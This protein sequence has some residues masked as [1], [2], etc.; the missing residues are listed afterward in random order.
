MSYKI[1]ITGGLIGLAMSALASVNVAIADENPFAMSE[2][3]AQG[4]SS[5]L[6]FVS[7]NLPQNDGKCGGGKC[8]DSDPKPK[9]GS[10]EPEPPS[11]C[12]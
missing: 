12:D 11:K 3:Q 5:Y 6:M 8:G 7:N 2:A 4:S 9:C 10:Q 1:G